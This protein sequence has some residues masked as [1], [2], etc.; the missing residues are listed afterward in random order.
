MLGLPRFTSTS[1]SRARSNWKR[2]GVNF[3]LYVCSW[4]DYCNENVSHKDNIKMHQE[5]D[6]HR[7]LSI[8]VSLKNEFLIVLYSRRVAS[9][10]PVLPLWCIKRCGSPSCRVLL[11]ATEWRDCAVCWFARASVPASCPGLSRIW[12]LRDSKNRCGTWHC[13]FFFSFSVLHS[14]AWQ[15]MSDV[16]LIVLLKIDFTFMIYFFVRDSSVDVIT[17]SNDFAGRSGVQQICFWNSSLDSITLQLTSAEP[18]HDYLSE[19]EN[20]LDF[21][22]AFTRHGSDSTQGWWWANGPVE[23]RLTLDRSHV[24]CHVVYCGH[25]GFRSIV[26]SVFCRLVSCS[27]WLSANFSSS[28]FSVCPSRSTSR[29]CY[30]T[31]R[32]DE[33]SEDI[34]NHERVRASVQPIVLS[35]RLI[36]S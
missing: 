25:R 18:F 34:V 19:K 31:N 36:A 12:I 30:W 8:A 11:T 33:K 32:D 14:T 29:S 35:V 27:E 28:T 2:C 20:V 15:M 23:W 9:I 16:L 22:S 7:F 4:R 1:R 26:L 6:T 13:W 5:A 21:T 17:L 3:R 24:W 10:L